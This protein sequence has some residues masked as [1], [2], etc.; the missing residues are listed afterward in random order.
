ML[1]DH[2]VPFGRGRRE[3]ISDRPIPFEELPKRLI[4]RGRKV[5]DFELSSSFHQ[6]DNVDIVVCLRE[7]NLSPAAPNSATAGP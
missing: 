3:W 6:K 7:T 4:P 1:N 5:K 2:V